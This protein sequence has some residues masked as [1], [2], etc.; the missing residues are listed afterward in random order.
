MPWSAPRARSG[1]LDMGPDSSSRTAPARGQGWPTTGDQ[2]WR[3]FRAGRAASVSIAALSGA[4]LF[5]NQRRLHTMKEAPPVLHLARPAGQRLVVGPAGTHTTKQG[6]GCAKDVAVRPCSFPSA[7]IQSRRSA[8][9]VAGLDRR[10][11]SDRA[12]SAEASAPGSRTAHLLPWIHNLDPSSARS[13][14]PGSF[15]WL[16]GAGAG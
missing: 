6:A 5:P 12:P 11:A 8:G 15:C 1:G 7:P 3:G 4:G 10:E 13:F 9:R 14:I 16:E 2:D